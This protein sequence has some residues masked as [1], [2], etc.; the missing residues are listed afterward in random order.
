[1]PTAKLSCI[2]DLRLYRGW[3]G[4]FPWQRL[5]MKNPKMPRALSCFITPPYSQ[6]RDAVPTL[7]VTRET[8]SAKCI[9]ESLKTPNPDARVDTALFLGVARPHRQGQPPSARK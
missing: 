1:M 6:L 9:S 5:H 8:H 7:S 3:R 2:M 4:L